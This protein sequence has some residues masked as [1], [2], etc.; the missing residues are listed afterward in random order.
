L[1]WVA[2]LAFGLLSLPA[3]THAHEAKPPAKP[4]EHD[5][6]LPPGDSRRPKPDYAKERRGTS[7]SQALLWIPRAVF[8]PLYVVTEYGIRQP[9][10]A[11]VTFAERHHLRAR[12]H[13]FFT[14]DEDQ[15]VGL[16]PSGRIDLGL[17]TQAG[18]YFFW[19][20]A[21]GQ[22]DIKLRLTTGGLD[23][24]TLNTLYHAPLDNLSYLR[25]KLDYTRRPDNT[26]YGL[27][28]QIREH[29]GRF[30][31]ERYTTGLTYGWSQGRLSFSA[32]GGFLSTSFDPKVGADSLAAAIASGALT[33]PPGLHDGVVAYYGGLAGR[34]D[35]RPAR[36]AAVRSARDLDPKSGTGISAGLHANHFVGLA[37]TSASA[38]QAKRRPHWLRFGGALLGGLDL[39]GTNRTL[40]LELAAELAEPLPADNPIPFT[41]QVSLGGD[42]P[43]RAFTSGRLIDES[44]A[45]AT[46]S[47]NWPVWS[48]LD[49]SIHYSLG[50]VFARHLEDFEPARLR[51]SFGIGMKTLGSPD[52]PFEALIALGTRPFAEGG[53]V[54]TLRLVFGT[55][56][57]F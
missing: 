26:F 55:Q 22:S 10:G 19:L 4:V 54:E 28:R 34:V 42:R 5:R 14:F 11:A 50:N 18:I 45:V 52:H 17:R 6:P 49:G 47:Y 9:V 57:G 39:T 23:T 3:A 53:G 25:L 46:L 8:F 40:E 15:K 36:L 24:W 12:Y 20:D 27:G 43:M 56:A 32:Q 38:A 30:E 41:E 33:A 35:T 44:A 21:T 37:P 2:R 31:A 29:G 16:F 13:E 48:Q 51:S 7:A 1:R